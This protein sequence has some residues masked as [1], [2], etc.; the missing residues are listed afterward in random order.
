[1]LNKIAGKLA[2]KLIRYSETGE[3]EIYIY[4]LELIIST[5]FSLLSILLVSCLLSSFTSGLVFISVFVPLRLFTGGYHAETYSK[6]FVISNLSY[7]L[8][9]FLKYIT[10]KIVPMEIWWCLLAGMCYYIIK[11]APIINPAQ[12]INESKQKRSKKIT[13]YI[14]IADIVWILSLALSRRELMAMAIL[15][16]CL[17]SA[18]ML[19]TEINACTIF[20]ERRD[21]ILRLLAKFVELCAV[22]GANCASLGM[23]YQPKMPKSL[24]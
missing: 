22:F 1:M 3:E 24:M 19:I 13:K 5:F 12:P 8:I 10:W 2:K 20:V 23:S 16:I 17:V 18:M 7:L 15:S 14:L 6:C 9:L 4:G 21:W 11:N